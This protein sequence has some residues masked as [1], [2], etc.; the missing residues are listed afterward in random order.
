MVTAEVA[1][2]LPALMLVLL[3]G[4]GAVAAVTAQLRCADAAEVAARLLARGET[5][6][7]ATAAA[8]AVAP[9]GAHIDAVTDVRT[10]TVVVSAPARLPGLGTWLPMVQVRE[11]FVQ[12][13][14]PAGSAL[15][16]WGFG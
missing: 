7:V 14:E 15:A 12:P 13:R 11:R 2:A 6:A 8:R 16:G 3:L 4:V 10:V 5:S 9:A 1:V